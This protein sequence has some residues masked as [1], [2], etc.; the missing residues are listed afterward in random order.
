VL[1][2]G[3]NSHLPLSLDQTD[4]KLS[5]P[6]IVSLAMH[7]DSRLSVASWSA[8]ASIDLERYRLLN[9]RHPVLT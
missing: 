6:F 2:L 3:K 4:R 7:T 9:R 1:E 8:I 5:R